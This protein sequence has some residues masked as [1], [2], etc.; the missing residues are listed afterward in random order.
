MGL[1]ET[2]DQKFLKNICEKETFNVSA[3]EKRRIIFD[4]CS[5]LK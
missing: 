2:V 4:V 5:K 1:T 3:S